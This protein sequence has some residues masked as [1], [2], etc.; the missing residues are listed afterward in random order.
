LDAH[1]LYNNKPIDLE[2]NKWKNYSRY[3]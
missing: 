3:Y 1:Y 2:F